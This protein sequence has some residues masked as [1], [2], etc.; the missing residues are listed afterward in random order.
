MIINLAHPPI[1][2]KTIVVSVARVQ[3]A[4]DDYDVTDY[5]YRR[6]DSIG[7]IS[8]TNVCPNAFVLIRDIIRL[9]KI[10]SC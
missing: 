5:Q 7:H 2:T 9:R 10:Y 3:A 8:S 1:E 6:L 4:H